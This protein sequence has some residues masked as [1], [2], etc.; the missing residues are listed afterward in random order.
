MKSLLDQ[1][2]TEK[3]KLIYKDQ[4]NLQYLN[5]VL[6]KTLPKFVEQNNQIRFSCYGS[7]NSVTV[8]KTG[9]SIIY[10]VNGDKLPGYLEKAYSL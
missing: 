6:Q 2:D 5:S 4:E 1:V 7:W 8:L 10:I 9:S 3:A